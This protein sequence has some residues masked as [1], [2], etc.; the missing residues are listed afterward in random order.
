MEALVAKTL[1]TYGRLGA[2]FNN[3]GVE[4][5]GPLTAASEADYRHVFDINVWGV[6]VAMKHEIPAMLQSGGG[7]MG[8][9]DEIANAVLYLCSEQ[10]SF[11]TGEALKVDGGW[12]AQ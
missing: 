6:I 10:S 7:R 12:T 8:R 11:V 3:A 9:A 5:L 2:A 1:A 4:M